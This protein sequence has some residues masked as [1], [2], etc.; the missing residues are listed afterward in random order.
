MHRYLTDIIREKR[1]ISDEV[2]QQAL[3]IQKKKGGRIGEILT[4]LRHINNEDL[5]NALS[6]RFGLPYMKEIKEEDIE[7]ELALKIP[8]SFAKKYEFLPINKKNG[9][10]LVA[11]SDP[12]NLPAID[13]L[14]ILL[15]SDIRLCIAPSNTI[16][17]LINRLHS[18]EMNKA[19][20]TMEELNVEDISFLSSEIEETE[21]LLDVTD[22][23]PIIRLVNSMFSQAIRDRASDIH[24]EPFEK[25]VVARFRI[26]GILYNILNIKKRFHPSISSR[27]KVMAGLNIAEKRLPQDGR[28]KIKIAGKDIDIRVSVIPVAF[29]ERIVLR[30]LYRENVLLSLEEIGL[31]GENLEKLNNLITKP[32]GIILVTGP[33]GSGKTTT[34]YS[35]LSKINSPDK[36]IITI[37]D[38]IEYQLRGIG[39]IQVNNKINL[40]F[41]NGLRSILR[42]DPDIILVGEIRDTETAE[43]AIQASLTGHLVF[44]TLHTNDA[45]GAITRLIDMKV[46]PFLVSSSL[47]AILAQRLVRVICP[48]CRIKYPPSSEEIK[49]LETGRIEAKN[50]H[51]YRAGGC[52]KCANTGYLGRTGIYELLIIDDDIRSLIM[53]DTDSSSIKNMAVKRGMLTLRQDGAG[54]VMKGI[55]TVDEVVRVTQR[56]GVEW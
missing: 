22:D 9:N 56:E 10:L 17:D 44:S 14:R 46:E 45:A 15:D 11:T 19:E 24:I 47:I 7:R 26:D 16:I 13:D 3:D 6:Q 12:L 30:L 27:I 4:R 8:I 36:N 41:A 40:T 50:I 33:T 39:Q 35:C 54:R 37:E 20:K 48:D 23:A 25:D 42:Q 21:D 43:I 31:S 52:E 49:R 2:I 38:P 1:P 29:G 18:K 53:K 34:L 32:H 55:T 28:I 5:L 51:F